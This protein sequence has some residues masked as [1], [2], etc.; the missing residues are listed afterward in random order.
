MSRV[1]VLVA[2]MGQSDDRLFRE[3]NLQTDAVLANQCD[4]YEYREY[5]EPD[6]SRVQLVSTDDRGVGKNRN[7]ALSF[8]SGEYLLCSDQDIIYVD[9]YSNIVED[10]FKKCPKA[11][12][13]VFRLEYLN[14]LTPFRKDTMRYRRV[15]LWN[16]MRYGAPRVAM[17]KAAVDKACLS[18]STLYGGGAKYSSGEDS[19]FIREALRKGLKMYT[20]PIVIARVKQEESSWFKGYNDKFF[21]DKGVLIANA[22]PCLKSLFLYYFAY[23]LRKVSKD[24][25]FRKICRLMRQGIREYKNL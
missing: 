15:H 13:I 9:G 19:L 3:M 18:F 5:T 25:G 1:Q 17:R 24:Y 6:G 21:I 10:A 4:C 23:G 22:F 7:K 8:A 11:D 12:I 20:C 16:C 2:C 14:H